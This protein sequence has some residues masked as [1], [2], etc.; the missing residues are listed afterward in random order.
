MTNKI[1]DWILAVQ[2]SVLGV[3][4]IRRLFIVAFLMACAA[5]GFA[6][7]TCPRT[8]WSTEWSKACF[9]VHGAVRKVKGQFVSKLRPSGGPIKILISETRELLAVDARGRVILPN[10]VYTG[11]FDLPNPDGVGRFAS[12]TSPK[13]GAKGQ[14]GYF[15][16]T[17]FKIIVAP[18][19][20]YCEAFS[21]GKA[22]AC[23]DC[24]AYC[25]DEECRSKTLVGGRGV[26]LDIEGKIRR[27]FA[28]PTMHEVCGNSD[29]VRIE[30]LINGMSKLHCSA[31]KSGPFDRVN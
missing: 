2:S 17:N 10:I 4:M 18:Q 9:E 30:K 20:D 23:V 29:D 14:C 21:D 27:R 11:D 16:E 1:V 22:Q 8:D 6:S 26:E 5:N 7:E 15:R 25:D 13:A 3:E 24:V 12:V 28:L 31:K 19:F